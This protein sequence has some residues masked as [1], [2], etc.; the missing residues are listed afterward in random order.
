VFSTRFE[1]DC[2]KEMQ[3]QIATLKKE[4][5]K[6]SADEDTDKVSRKEEMQTK[7]T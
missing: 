4:T 7:V 3:T 6:A 5:V 1:K 2:L